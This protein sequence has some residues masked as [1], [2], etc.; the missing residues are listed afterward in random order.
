MY[1]LAK[2]SDQE[3]LVQYGIVAFKCY[4]MLIEKLSHFNFAPEVTE[5]IINQLTSKIPQVNFLE[6]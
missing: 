1:N 4:C 3:S 2:K 5:I 6:T